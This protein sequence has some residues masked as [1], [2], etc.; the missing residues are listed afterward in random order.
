MRPLFSGGSSGRS[1]S[2]FAMSHRR[3]GRHMTEPYKHIPF[4]PRY[5]KHMQTLLCHVHKRLVC[6]ILGFKVQAWPCIAK[7]PERM[8][9]VAPDAVPG[10]S[11][12]ILGALL[13]EFTVVALEKVNSITSCKSYGQCRSN[14]H[15]RERFPPRLRGQAEI[16]SKPIWNL[17]C[18]EANCKK[19]AAAFL[20]TNQALIRHSLYMTKLDLI[21]PLCSQKG[22]GNQGP[23]VGTYVSVMADSP[24]FRS[25]LCGVQHMATPSGSW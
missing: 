20:L 19:P 13:N 8:P 23:V 24:C 5:A 7:W 21:E 10:A 17:R 11:C 1:S 25:K 6:L 14:Q 22:L 12:A 2:Q 18:E 3:S 4:L 15:C 16:R 9:V